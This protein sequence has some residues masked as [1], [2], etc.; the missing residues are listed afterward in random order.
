MKKI[1]LLFLL[2]CSLTQSQIAF[3]YVAVFSDETYRFNESNDDPN[4]DLLI[5][6]PLIN[7]NPNLALIVT[8]DYGPIGPYL[9]K[10]LYVYFRPSRSGGTWTI[11]CYDGIPDNAKFNVLAVPLGER[12]FK[13]TITSDTN[14][15][16]AINHPLLNGNPTAKFLIC[17]NGSS[18]TD[19]VGVYY[20][21]SK[22]NIFNQNRTPLKRGNYFIVIDNTIFNVEA[23]NP[24]FHVNPIDNASTNNNP[25]ALVFT[26]QLWTSVYNPNHTGVFYQNNKWRIFNQSISALP[27]GTKFFMLSLPGTPYTNTDNEVHI[28]LDDILTQLCPTSVISGDREFDGHGPRIEATVS[29]EKRNNT[30]IWAII[31]FSATETVSDFSRTEAIFEKKVFTAPTGK[32]ID[33]ILSTD[34]TSHFDFISRPG[35]FQIIANNDYFNEDNYRK[36]GNDVLQNF[37][38]GFIRRISFVG[39]T[40]GNDISTDTDCKDDTRI[41]K[42]LFRSIKIRYIN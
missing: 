20:A 12:A 6:N 28:K 22:W 21:G 30:E 17:N 11:R 14:S 42:I 18:N 8:P 36:S 34:T 4:Y 39:D 9:N 5:D 1:T 40:G 25:N 19:P 2:I 41:E 32:Q 29:L 13:H 38:S 10:S 26:T 7:N 16:S 3:K 23:T 35:G 24:L 27:R 37:S 15:T 31:L 33:V